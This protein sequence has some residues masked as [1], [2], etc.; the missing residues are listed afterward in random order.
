MRQGWVTSACYAALLVGLTL[1]QPDALA[2]C[3]IFGK[4]PS[5]S[6]LGSPNEMLGGCSRR[7]MPVKAIFFDYDGV[8]TR[9]K[10]GSL[11]MNRFVSEQTGIPYESVSRAFSRHNKDLNEGKSCYDEI[12]PA[13]CAELGRDLPRELLIRAFESTPVNERMFCL[14]RELKRAYSVGIITDNKK[15]RIDY[16][17]QYQRLPELFAPIVVSAEV[18]CTKA[19]ARIFQLA[20]AYLQV[21]PEDAVFIDNT[22]CNLVAA[23]AIGIKTVLFDDERNDVAGLARFLHTEYGVST[24]GSA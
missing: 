23:A 22:P 12:W 21:D 10:T 18:R 2:Y 3:L 24:P 17:R 16:L 20:S 13:L 7:H 19:D 4:H 9:D 15:D 1:W 6:N 5:F 14:A 11:T 8:L